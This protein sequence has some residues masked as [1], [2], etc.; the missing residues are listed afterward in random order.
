MVY[1][2]GAGPGDPELLTVR[3]RR[4]LQQ[5]DVV[6]YAGSLVNPAILNV[7]RPGAKLVDSAPL[8]LEQIITE[9]ARAHEQGLCIVRLHTGDPCLY[10]A[11]GEQ[12]K[13]LDKRQIPYRVIP[14]VSSF[15]AAAAALKREYTVPGG[16]QTV[17]ITRAA[18]RTPV[19]DSERLQAL[20][21]HRSGMAIFLSAG[22]AGKVQQQLLQNYPGDTP[23]ALVYKASWPEEKVVQGRLDQLQQMAEE[24]N[25][26][27]TALILVGEFLQK[28][29]RSKL[30]HRDFTHGYRR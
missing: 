1:I 16:S 19:P 27:S 17:I 7:C 14:G 20:A 6:I 4:I 5:A 28:T 9:I 8:T 3:G 13:E 22:L 25:I 12:M 18:G 30:Y 10:G 24:N 26:K 29:G 11:I 15:S 21:A 2:V 23:V